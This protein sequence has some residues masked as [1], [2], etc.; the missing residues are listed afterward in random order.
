MKY[1]Q[2]ED[3]ANETKQN[4]SLKHYVFW[5]VIAIQG[6][7][8]DWSS[9][10]SYMSNEKSNSSSIISL[11]LLLKNTGKMT[12]FAKLKKVSRHKNY[13]GN[14]CFPYSCASLKNRNLF[15]VSSSFSTKWLFCEA[16]VIRAMSPVSRN[17]DQ[18]QSHH[19]PEIRW[20]TGTR[21]RCTGSAQALG[22]PDR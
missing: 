20:H 19:L 3:R 14:F 9:L 12:G 4:H 1:F 8:G 21:N 13:L 15:L 17:S 10:Y 5:D 2:N 6:I 16:W 22:T 7:W 18:K 11:F